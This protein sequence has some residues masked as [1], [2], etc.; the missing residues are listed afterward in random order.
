MH[1]VSDPQFSHFV[2]PPLPI[3]NDRSLGSQKG[4]APPGISIHDDIKGEQCMYL[5]LSR[6]RAF[7]P[8]RIQR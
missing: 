1:K 6:E 3:I 2:A 4:R 7:V 8:T 5:L